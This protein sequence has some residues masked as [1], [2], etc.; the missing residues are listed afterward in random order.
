MIVVGLMSGTSADGT[1]VAV[2]EIEG[3]PPELNWRLHHFHE[4]PHPPKLR[5]AILE[6]ADA[7]T[8]TVDKLCI[9]NVRLGEQLA[10][11]KLG[12]GLT[13]PTPSRGQAVEY[14]FV[15]YFYQ[16]AHTH[17]QDYAQ[18]QPEWHNFL[19][20]ITKAHTLKAWQ[21]VLDFVQVL[22]AIPLLRAK[23]QF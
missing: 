16:Y 3:Q 4:V 23:K 15:D 9:L 19:A 13:A 5:H 21:A 14:A 2:V 18:L 17:Q 1:D 8:G 20:G 7:K 10:A 12:D 11:E 22:V 6:A